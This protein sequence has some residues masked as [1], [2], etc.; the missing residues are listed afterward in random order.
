MSPVPISQTPPSSSWRGNHC[1]LPVGSR[2]PP[3]HVCHEPGSPLLPLVVSET[4]EEERP[5]LLCLCLPLHPRRTGSTFGVRCCRRAAALMRCVPMQTLAAE[6]Q[7][8]MCRHQ[9]WEHQTGAVRGTRG[10]APLDLREG[11]RAQLPIHMMRAVTWPAHPTV[12]KEG[13]KGERWGKP[14]ASPTEHIL[15]FQR[16]HPLCFSFHAAQEPK[17]GAT[18]G[19]GIWVLLLIRG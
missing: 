19:V 14:R 2:A 12:R 7:R 15:P 9:P 13:N 10:P 3:R 8:V 16:P 4:T 18:A 17:D 5:R 1:S 6:V 11:S